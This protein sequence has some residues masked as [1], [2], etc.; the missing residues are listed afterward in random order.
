MKV[1]DDGLGAV[2]AELL[3][4]DPALH[5]ADLLAFKIIGR[6]DR[7]ICAEV[8][9]AVLPKG[10]PH[11]VDR[12][13]LCE[14]P[15]A[16][17]AIKHG[18]EILSFWKEEGEIGMLHR[19]DRNAHFGHRGQEYVD[20][21]LSGKLDHLMVV[22]ELLS[23]IDLD[24]DTPLCS[25]LNLIAVAHRR[26]MQSAVNGRIVSKSK[27]YPGRMKIGLFTLSLCII[28]RIK[29]KHKNAKQ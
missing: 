28:L 17:F 14:Q 26:F 10:D 2:G 22:A 11:K 27:L 13:K 12:F 29:D 5:D 9:K 16:H 24:L 20:L 25:F 8:F 4:D 6:S 1:Y 21:A 7:R 19:R 18:V 15:L 23:G 3:L